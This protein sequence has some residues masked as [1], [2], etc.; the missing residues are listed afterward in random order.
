MKWLSLTVYLLAQLTAITGVTVI[1][2]RD[3]RVETGRTVLVQGKQIAA[4]QPSSAKF[5]PGSRRIDGAGKFLI[6]GL[7]DSHVHLSKAGVLSLSL[8]IANGITSVRDMGSNF[9]EVAKWRS[10]V[11]SGTVIG[12][13]IKTSGQMLESRANIERMKREG[14]IEPV[15]RLRIG[16]ANPREGRAAVDRL[17]ALGV[18]HIKMRTTPDLATFLAVGEEA[19]L[20]H[21]PFAA[22]P[23]DTPAQLIQARLKS[24]EHFLTYPALRLPQDQLFRRIKASGLLF[25]NT[26]ANIPGLELTPAAAAAR[27]NEDPLRKYVCGYLANDWR[28]QLA[29]LKD[30]P[31]SFPAEMSAEYRNFRAMRQAGIPFLAGTDVAVVFM[32]P[33]F[34]LHKEL[35]LLV[36]EIGFTPMEALRIASYNPHL[37]YADTQN[38][39]SI[40]SG[41]PADL[42]LLDADPI[43]DIRNTK[44]IRGVM[45]AGRWFD[46]QALDQVLTQAAQSCN[47]Q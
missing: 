16:V 43:S 44:Q 23:V 34:S 9:E 17:A 41:Q 22:H 7:W 2:P 37:F 18:D 40:E 1:N 39:G 25:S 14:T 35:Q 27:L 8:F 45:F 21:L 33:G 13:H 47:V 19:A 29:E 6:P 24:V 46:R 28:E 12:P 38:N 42:V 30:Y 32:Y 36:T 5:P 31:K 26:M 15:D 20:H 4:V 3:G 11:E 10:Q